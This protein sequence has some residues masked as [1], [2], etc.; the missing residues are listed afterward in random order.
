MDIMQV[1]RS[2][3]SCRRYRAE[4]VSSAVLMN[5][6]DAGRLAPTSKG[7]QPWEFVVVTDASTLREIAKLTDFG[8]FIASAAACIAVF[9]HRDA[10]AVIE[11]CAA[12]TEN[13]LIAASGM[14]LG[15]CWVAGD[16]KPYAETVASILR[17]PPDLKLV[18]LV[19]VGVPAEGIPADRKKRTLEEVLHWQHF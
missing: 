3:Y 5:L 9:G 4:P 19:S 8:P 14:G 17:A 18:S 10:R 15:A 1:I 6:V 7:M 16:K 12:A 2:R 13:I 11:D